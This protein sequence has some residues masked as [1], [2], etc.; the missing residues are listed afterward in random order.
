MRHTLGRLLYMIGDEWWG[1]C[2]WLGW[3]DFDLQ[4]GKSRTHGIVM[5]T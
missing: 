4:A 5:M 3:D 1:K 2:E